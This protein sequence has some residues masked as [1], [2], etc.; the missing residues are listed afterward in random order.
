MR[1]IIA[2]PLVVAVALAAC[3][4]KA[5]DTP[6][7]VEQAAE[8]VKQLAKPEPGKYKST[9][10]VLEF[11]IPGLPPEQAKQMKKVM[12]DAAA[13]SHEFCLT[14]EDV[15]KGYEEMVKKSSEGS[16]TF[17]KF[18]T[19]ANSLDAKMTC[20][21]DEGAKADMTLTGTMAPTKS[22]MVMEIDHNSPQLPGGK[23]HTKMEVTNE[24]IGDCG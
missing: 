13:Q 21:M 7:T 20:D 1:L 2:L 11:D 19:S 22:V 16:C 9:V 10:K 18:E 23:V 24:R 3:D 15:E 14:P 5:A 6:K 12:G 4:K 17:A 8:Q